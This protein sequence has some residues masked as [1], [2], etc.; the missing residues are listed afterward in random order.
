MKKCLF[1]KQLRAYFVQQ[2]RSGR[3]L[4]LDEDALKALLEIIR[5]Q[6]TM[7]LAKKLKCLEKKKTRQSNIILIPWQDQQVWNLV[8]A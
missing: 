7:E 5:R 8:A 1:C 6:K 3:P 4:K 2:E